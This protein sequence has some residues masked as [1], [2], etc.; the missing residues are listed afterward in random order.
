MKLIKFRIQRYKSI[1]DSGWCW[2]ASDITTLAGKNESGKS[3]ILEGLRDFEL[4]VETWP[5][6]AVPIDDSGKPMI[7][8]CFGEVEES[9]LDAIVE[10]TKIT[11]SGEVREYISKNNV[12]IIKYDNCEYGLEEE[13]KT[14]LNK[15]REELNS[16]SIKKIKQVV[17]NLSK[18]EWLS[19]ITKPELDDDIAHTR[20]RVGLHIIEAED[21]VA[22]IPDEETK[23]RV[24]EAI[25]ELKLANDA[26]DEED[27]ASKFVDELVRHTPDFIFFRD[28]SDILPFE[29]PLAE[30]KNRNIVEDF[31][32]VS[33]LD[34]DKVINTT[35]S[36]QRR[37]IGRAHV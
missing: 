8:M 2:L 7:E 12:T 34:L 37:K 15:E 25:K 36:Q 6:G 35:D 19:G 13:I 4:D 24:N 32:K 11:I 17:G 16:K 26:L 29:L 10:E 27:V 22:S 9:V 30:A 20:E 18:I 14:F 28:F 3:A 23:Q 1:K 21:R 5:D 33:G 31:A